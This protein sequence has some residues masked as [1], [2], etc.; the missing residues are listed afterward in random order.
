MATDTD[1]PLSVGIEWSAR[2]RREKPDRKV[3]SHIEDES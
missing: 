1:C 2:L 3:V